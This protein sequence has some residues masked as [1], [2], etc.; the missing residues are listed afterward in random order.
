MGSNRNRLAVLMPAYNVARYIDKSIESILNQTYGAFDFYI[1]DD[2]ST[3]DTAE[4]IKAYAHKDDRI[5]PVYNLQNEGIIESRNKLFDLCNHKYIALMDADDIANRER[6]KRQIDFLELNPHIK[7]VTSDIEIIPQHRIHRDSNYNDT[8][9]EKMIFKNII[10]NP[11]SMMHSD[12]IQRYGIRY[13]PDYRGS[14]DYKFWIDAL[15][16]TQGYILDEVLLQYRR[17]GAQ[18]STFNTLRQKKHGIKVT[19]QQLKRLDPS[20]DYELVSMMVLHSALKSSQRW[21]LFDTYLK[22]LA[23]NDKKRVFRIEALTKVVVENI[24]ELFK[25]EPSRTYIS[26]LKRMRKHRLIKSPMFYKMLFSK[27]F[28]L[29]NDYN[30]SAR[31]HAENL[32]KKVKQMRYHSISIYGAGEISE[33]FFMLLEQNA[34]DITVYDVYDLKAKQYSYDIAGYKVKDP[35]TISCEGIDAIVVGSFQFKDEI[36]EYLQNHAMCPCPILLP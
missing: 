35:A 14:S 4:I 25:N 7:I 36:L 19:W 29:K 18:E 30:K 17:H 31:R 11:S 33:Y 16:Y 9:K 28:L 32:Y 21:E 24:H 20:I 12:I 1:L 6:L 8:F 13:D 5:I 34:Y 2:N 15:E 23:L 3:D 10:N 27:L 26:M 22:L